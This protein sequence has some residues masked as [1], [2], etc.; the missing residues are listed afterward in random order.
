MIQPCCPCNQQERELWDKARTIADL[1]ELTARW[2][3]R[4]ISWNPRYT[5]KLGPRPPENETTRIVPTLVALNRAGLLTTHSTPGA[6]KCRDAQ[7]WVPPE[8][9][10]VKGHFWRP[11]WAER[12]RWQQATVNCVADRRDI[13]LVR[14]IRNHC[15]REGMGFLSW[16]GVD[17]DLY[18]VTL[19]DTFVGALTPRPSSPCDFSRPQGLSTPRPSMR[20]LNDLLRWP[21]IAR[22]A[23]ASAWWIRIEDPDV[24]RSDRLWPILDA[25][26]NGHGR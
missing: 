2:L 21:D 15:H 22:N 6:V 16:L 13:D 3:A 7:Y 11:R 24:G 8:N 5:S 25:W 26:A 23:L 14:S 10:V 20:E 9:G 1:G 18:G 17:T 19:P 4:D 12:D